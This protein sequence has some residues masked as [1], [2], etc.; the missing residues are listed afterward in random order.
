MAWKRRSRTERRRSFNP[1]EACATTKWSRRRIV[2][3][4]RW[5]SRACATSGTKSRSELQIAGVLI[6]D[7]RIHRGVAETR[8]KT[9]RKHRDHRRRRER[10]GKRREKPKTASTKPAEL[11]GL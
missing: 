7:H 9:R 8:S 6:E 10:R 5:C 2:S 4:S 11:S 1:A 3:G